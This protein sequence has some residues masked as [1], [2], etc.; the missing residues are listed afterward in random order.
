[1]NRRVSYQS[2]LGPL[3]TEGAG[4]FVRLGDEAISTRRKDASRQVNVSFSKEQVRWLRDVTQQAGPEVDTDAVVRAC[5]D[6]GRELGI[7]WGVIGGG[8]ALRAAVRESVMVR[9]TE[10]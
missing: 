4:G 8:K 5:V 6:L 1:M 2:V 7:D 3:S 9:R 10:T